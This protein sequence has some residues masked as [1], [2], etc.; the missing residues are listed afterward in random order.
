MRKDTFLQEAD[1]QFKKLLANRM[2]GKE[3]MLVFY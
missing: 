2:I 1:S 3:R